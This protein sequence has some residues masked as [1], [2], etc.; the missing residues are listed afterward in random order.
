MGVAAYARGNKLISEQIRR[1]VEASRL[2]PVDQYALQ[3]LEDERDQLRAEVAALR[4]D[5]DRAIRCIR[6]MEAGRTVERVATAEQ[7]ERL[8]GR[9]HSAEHAMLRFRRQWERVSQLLRRVASP[10]AVA[11]ARAEAPL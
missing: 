5:R 1:D 6:A 4:R 9:A 8:S 11:E 3:A 10:M 7:I 2:V